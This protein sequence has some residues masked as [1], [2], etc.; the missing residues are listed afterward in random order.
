VHDIRII[1]TKTPQVNNSLRGFL[2]KAIPIVQNNSNHLGFRRSPHPAEI[3][4]I[5]Q[6]LTEDA[7]IQ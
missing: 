2:I 1:I 5:P 6:L 4:H 7:V 3:G